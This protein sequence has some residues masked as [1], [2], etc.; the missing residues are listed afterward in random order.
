MSEILRWAD[1]SF[2]ADAGAVR[3]LTGLTMKGSCETEDAVVDEEK[4]AK[5]KNA[6]KYEI[7]LDAILDRRLG[8]DVQRTA[9]ALTERARQGDEGYIYTADGKLFPF[10]LMLV[11]ADVSEVQFTGNGKW[12]SCRVKMNLAQCAKYN[13]SKVTGGGSSGGSGGAVKKSVRTTDPVMISQKLDGDVGAAAQSESDALNKA[14]KKQSNDVMARAGMTTGKK[15]GLVQ[16]DNLT[17]ATNNN[18][19]RGGGTGGGRVNMLN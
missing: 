3:G 14:A 17:G 16:V 8:E 18:G 4:F 13:G 1:V 9:A 12:L 7:S 2:F 5:R 10:P 6:G 15:G 19:L 11:S